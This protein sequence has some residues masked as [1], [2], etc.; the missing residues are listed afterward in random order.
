M[1]CAIVL[2]HLGSN[3]FNKCVAAER[4]TVSHLTFGGEKMLT[5]ISTTQWAENCDKKLGFSL[6]SRTSVLAN[7][8]QQKESE[9]GGNMFKS[10]NIRRLW[11]KGSLYWRDS[12]FLVHLPPCSW[13]VIKHF[14]LIWVCCGNPSHRNDAKPVT[15][16]EWPLWK[17]VTWA[18]EQRWP[19]EG[20]SK[21]KSYLG[22]S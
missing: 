1:C 14:M 15:R 4:A 12:A 21:K 7:E 11:R 6:K 13:L 18:V 9:V 3:S 16:L 19:T 22:Q 17:T 2:A 8:T 5:Y 20:G 10:R